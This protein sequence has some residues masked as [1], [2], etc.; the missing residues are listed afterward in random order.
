MCNKTTE[1]MCPECDED[2]ILKDEFVVQQ[3]PNCSKP[4]LPCSICNHLDESGN[5]T[6][7]RC[8]TCPLEKKA[9]KKFDVYIERCYFVCETIEGIEAETKEEAEQKAIEMFPHPKFY[10]DSRDNNVDGIEE[11][12]D[13]VYTDVQNEY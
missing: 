6:G 2:V 8:L 4:I 13:G 3:C 12:L 9:L 7:I 5:F 1:E 10:I 11:T